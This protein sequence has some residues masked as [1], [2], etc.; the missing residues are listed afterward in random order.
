M[1]VSVQTV[2]VS[3]SKA[4][5]GGILANSRTAVPHAFSLNIDKIQACNGIFIAQQHWSESNRFQEPAKANSYCETSA[6]YDFRCVTI[7]RLEES[8]SVEWIWDWQNTGAPARYP[9][10][11]QWT[12]RF[13]QWLQLC[14]NGRLSDYD[15]GA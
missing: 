7:R 9:A 5:R 15:G 13:D 1:F 3:W 14:W 10:R 8:V 4:A 6:I 11:H 12:L 2:R